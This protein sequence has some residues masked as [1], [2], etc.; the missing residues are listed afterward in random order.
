M[1]YALKPSSR[2]IDIPGSNKIIFFEDERSVISFFHEKMKEDLVVPNSKNER[3][4]SWQ[5][6][7]YKHSI[8]DSDITSVYSFLVSKEVDFIWLSHST[9]VNKAIREYLGK[10]HGVWQITYRIR[11][12]PM[13]WSLYTFEEHKHGKIMKNIRWGTFWR[14]AKKQE[15]FKDICLAYKIPEK[16]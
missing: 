5:L 1:K 2:T 16:E 10:Q 15:L 6:K 11:S 12:L 9:R 4:N 8:S 7:N 3:L 14:Q 13:N